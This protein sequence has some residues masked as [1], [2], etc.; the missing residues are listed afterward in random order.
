MITEAWMKIGARPAVVEQALDLDYEIS[1]MAARN[2]AGDVR[3]YPAARNHHEVRQYLVL[4][5]ARR[6]GQKSPVEYCIKNH[7]DDNCNCAPPL[8]R[9]HRRVHPDCL[10]DEL[11]SH[12]VA[13][14]P[15]PKFP[16][17]PP[18]R[19]DPAFAPL[20]DIPA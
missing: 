14:A 6:V 17:A 10:K 4:M 2:P 5:S 3:S 15:I 9:R 16:I 8:L 11:V 20:Q 18:N 13:S 1:V 12:L 7:T 19:R